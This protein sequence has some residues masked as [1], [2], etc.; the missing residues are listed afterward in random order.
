MNKKFKNKF[1]GFSRDFLLDREN[2]REEQKK[3][4]FNLI[5][6]PVFQMLKKS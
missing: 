2:T 6:Y 4:T 5:Y 3:I 1:Y